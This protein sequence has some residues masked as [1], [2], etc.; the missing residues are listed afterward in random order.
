MEKK[1]EENITNKYRVL[2]FTIA[3]A[4]FMGS[5][6]VTI[7][8][9][10][11]PSISS[12]YGISTG[13]VS[14]VSLAYL[15]VLS[16]FMLISGK[17]AANC[18]Y[19]RIF[20]WGFVIFSAGSLLCG[21]SP[22]L[23]SAFLPLIFFR[24]F[25]ALGASVMSALAPG[26]VALYLPED[27]R[28]KGLSFIVIMASAGVAAGPF[29]GGI[30]TE[31]AG[32]NWIFLI[33]VPVGIFAVICGLLLIP[34]DCIRM[35]LEG[36]D[37][38]GSFLILIS[39]SAGIFAINMGKELGWGSLIITG[40]AGLSVISL[41]LFYLNEKRHK[42]PLLEI[43][44]FKNRAF[45][46]ANSAAAVIML[47]FTGASFLFPF[48]LEY[49]EGLSPSVSGM[50]LIIP[51]AA[52]I[53]GGFIAGASSDKAESAKLCIISSVLCGISFILFAMLCGDESYL[54][55]FTGLCLLGLSTGMFIPANSSLI[56]SH[57]EA[58]ET[59]VVS[60]LMMTVRDTGA[61]FGIAVFEMV[62]AAVIYSGLSAAKVSFYAP[63]V[64]NTTVL[65]EGF[66]YTFLAGAVICTL[67]VVFSFYAKMPENKSFPKK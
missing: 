7:V 29:L 50:I 32:W 18:G 20:L 28:T 53:A 30:L 10:A 52:M 48:Y 67:A 23:F 34:K 60:A 55:L 8:N 66:K 39:L 58:Y 35:K 37:I 46:Y 41:I 22:L 51:S 43:G 36:F 15:I 63:E 49:I 4:A 3:L 54:F 57:S 11:L 2:L 1:G 45:S 40:T 59:G 61:S 38:E 47:V 12:G 62:F 25:Q 26:M 6:D 9:I 31:Y 14:W 13:L 33:N 19:K 21:L 64:M 17:I 27:M 24:V 65:A 44:I 56:F 42:N 16:S 5:L